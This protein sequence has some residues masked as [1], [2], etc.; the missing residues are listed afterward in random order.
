MI[1]LQVLRGYYCRICDI[2]VDKI[3]TYNSRKAKICNLHRG[4]THRLDCKAFTTSVTVEVYEHIQ[5]A[6]GNGISAAAVAPVTGQVDERM[7]FLLD[8]LAI[9]GAVVRSCGKN[10]NLL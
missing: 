7:S 1:W 5:F 2:V 3:G 4:R 9:K 10:V 8:L 6:L